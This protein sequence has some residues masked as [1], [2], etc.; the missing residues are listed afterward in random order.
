MQIRP[1]SY[2]FI[3]NTNLNET[4]IMKW[5][6]VALMLMSVVVGV[7]CRKAKSTSA[8]ADNTPSNPAEAYARKVPVI[9]RTLSANDLKNL[10]LFLRSAYDSTGKWPRSLNDVKAAMQ[11]DPDARK[12]LAKIEDGTYIVIWNP[13]E[14]GILAHTGGSDMHGVV[15]V[16]TGGE[17]RNMTAG[18]FREAMAQ[19]KR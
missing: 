15:T 11:Q 12:L 18:E 8:P 1:D 4:A 17:V 3:S 10:H 5:I 16:T 7:G 6:F 2:N 19:Q 13:P 9:D 14:G